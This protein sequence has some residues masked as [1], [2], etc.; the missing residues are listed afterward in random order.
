MAPRRPT[1]KRRFNRNANKKRRLVRVQRGLNTPAVHIFR[2]AL[3][4][5][6]IL[7]TNTPPEGWSTSG[8]NLYKNWG[9]SLTSL[10]SYTE[11]TDLFKYYKLSGARV[12]MYFSN[13]NS[14]AAGIG[15]TTAGNYNPNSQ[16]MMHIDTNND[17][18]DLASSG[19][20]QTYLDS[21]TAK[22]KLCLNTIG[23][24]IDI[25]MPLKQQSVLYGTTSDDY[26]IVKPK[27]ISTTEPTTPHFGFKM[28]L[29]R[30][31]G[32]NFSGPTTMANSQ[33]CKIITTLYLQ[34]KKVQ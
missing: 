15:D 13:T 22:K 26:A 2:R 3:T 33:Y 25:Y 18:A 21:Q 30:V 6:I 28:M 14:S 23:K 7:S 31:D 9:F 20:E 34:T 4:Q 19:L 12:Q 8:N 27:W 24:P 5:T 29:Q 10:G 11:F 16:I 32:Q 1:K 17:G